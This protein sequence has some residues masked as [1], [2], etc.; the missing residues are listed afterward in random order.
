MSSSLSSVT[1]RSCTLSE[2]NILGRSTGNADKRAIHEEDSGL[3][4]VSNGPTNNRSN[5]HSITNLKLDSSQFT[6]KSSK[7]SLPNSSNSFES[8][9]FESV[10][11]M[12]DILK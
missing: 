2:N 10:R 3:E 1:N 4:K 5:Y 7:L 11:Y 12:V 6:I 8:I 9:S